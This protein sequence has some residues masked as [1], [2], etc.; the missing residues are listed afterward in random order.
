[1]KAKKVH[2][3]EGFTRGG[4]PYAKLGIG[5]KIERDKRKI[6]A[7]AEE[8]GYKFNDENRKVGS[9][10]ISRITVPTRY[11]EPHSFGSNRRIGDSSEFDVEAIQYTFTYPPGW[12]ET[13]ISLRKR[14]LR[15]D[16]TGG[17]QNLMGR[18]ASIEDALKRVSVN[19]PKEIAKS[20]R[21]LNFSDM[22][23]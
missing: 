20:M 23:P 7:Y 18:F 12:G 1:M 22:P 9:V 4:D 14:W 8:R 21:A 15:A 5:D 13:P 19:I 17:K 10:T 2:E 16:G 11:N 3:M 6:R